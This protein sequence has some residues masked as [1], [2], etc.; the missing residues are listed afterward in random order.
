MKE[1]AKLNTKNKVQ[2]KALSEAHNQCYAADKPC[3]Q[4][5]RGANMGLSKIPSEAQM[6]KRASSNWGLQGIA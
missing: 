3:M 1:V 2:M 6:H 4:E 5:V